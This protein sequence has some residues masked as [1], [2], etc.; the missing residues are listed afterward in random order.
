MQSWEVCTCQTTG[1]QECSWFNACVDAHRVPTATAK[2]K[3]SMKHMALVNW[4]MFMADRSL[5]G[6]GRRPPIITAVSL[7]HHSE[8]NNMPASQPA[9]LKCAAHSS[10]LMP[11]AHVC[12]WRSQHTLT[13]KYMA[14]GH[15][16]QLHIWHRVKW[17]TR[18]KNLV[19]EIQLV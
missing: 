19:V 3:G 18:L 11:Q 5:S 10:N 9:L 16:H 1:I 8:I 6:S 4:K 2:P 7:A 17:S 12:G 13:G 15:K 14:H